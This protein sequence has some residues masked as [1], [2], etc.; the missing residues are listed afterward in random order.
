M[1]APMSQAEKLVWAASFARTLH[2][3]DADEAVRL[4]REAGANQAWDKSAMIH[5]FIATESEGSKP[6]P[7]CGGLAVKKGKCLGC[8]TK[9]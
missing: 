8:G 7:T 3:E 9:R 6:C 1:S 2:S 4:L 5:T